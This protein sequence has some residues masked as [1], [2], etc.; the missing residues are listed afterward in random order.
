MVC[1]FV[2]PTEI[3]S[4]RRK[5]KYVWNRGIRGHAGSRPHPAGRP[6]P[7]GVPRLRLG[8]HGCL[9][10]RGLAGLQD[11]RPPAGAGRFDGG[12]PHPHRYAGRGPYP[13]GHPW[14]AQ[15]HQRPSPGQPERPVRRCPQRHHRELRPAPRPAHRQ[16]LRLPLRDGHGGGG[17]AAGLLLR[18]QPRRVRGSEQ[19]ALRRGGRLRA[20]Y[21]LRR[22]AGP[23]HC[24]PQGRAAAAGLRRR[25]ELHRLRRD[26][27]AAPHTGYR[28]H[29]RRRAGHR[30]MR[31]HPHL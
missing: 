28:V 27:A 4:F 14:R 3:I 31:R 16:G 2:L 8:G 13:L 30:H 17:P 10:P 20:G 1:A 18:R 5:I 23:A 11:Q 15:R 19:H 12:G 22:R 26:G 29:G 6:A 21:R 7:S 25:R 9:R 24:R